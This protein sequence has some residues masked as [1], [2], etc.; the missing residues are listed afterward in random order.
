MQGNAPS[1]TCHNQIICKLLLHIPYLFT[2]DRIITFSIGLV[3]FKGNCDNGKRLQE[4]DVT[5]KD[6][7]DLF[8]LDC[9]YRPSYRPSD[10][11][12]LCKHKKGCTAFE[13]SNTCKLLGGGPFT[14]GSGDGR[15]DRCFVMEGI[16]IS[17]CLYKNTICE[18]YCCYYYISL[19]VNSFLLSL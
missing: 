12:Q 1:K 6:C 9:S 17:S 3:V 8:K 5:H 14:S 11:H 4:I 2:F 18:C 13:S 16:K 10:C 7:Y 15:N 19:Q